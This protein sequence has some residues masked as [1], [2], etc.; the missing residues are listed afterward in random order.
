MIARDLMATE[1]KKERA[2]G[3]PANAE[4]DLM[5]TLQSEKLLAPYV[6]TYLAM[7]GWSIGPGHLKELDVPRF[8]RWKAHNLPG[9]QPRWNVMFRPKDGRIF[10]EVPGEDLPAPGDLD[11]RRVSCAV[12][13]ARLDQALRRWSEEEAR[14]PASPISAGDGDELLRSLERVKDAP[15]YSERGA[16]WVPDRVFAVHYLAG[17][18]AVDGGR[19]DEAEKALRKAAALAPVSAHARSELAHVYARTGRLDQAAALL[20]EAL[21]LAENDCERAR[22]LRGQGF[23]LVERRNLLEA[24]QAYARSLELDPSSAVATKE[25]AFIGSELRR[26]G[27]AEAAATLEKLQP[28]R[29]ESRV[30]SC[31]Q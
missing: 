14:L 24:F 6:V 20:D 18:C 10:P 29:I 9:H 5:V 19:W 7:P 4:L 21:P 8:R 23:V 26:T 13:R 15:P 30:T 3:L 31:P 28:H 11:P 16:I 27:R 2:D 17:F 12:S 22:I 25:I 1:W